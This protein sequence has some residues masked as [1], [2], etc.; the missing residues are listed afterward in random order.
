MGIEEYRGY[1]LDWVLPAGLAAAR[2]GIK[3]AE[4]EADLTDVK[5][6]PVV[7]TRQDMNFL[8]ER[9]KRFESI[10]FKK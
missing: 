4:P 10:F 5:L 6:L 9:T 8:K 2:K 7:T 3:A 1:N